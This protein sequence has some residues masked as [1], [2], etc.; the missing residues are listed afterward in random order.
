MWVCVRMVSQKWYDLFIIFLPPPFSDKPMWYFS[1]SLNCPAGESH[2]EGLG[3]CWAESKSLGEIQT[4]RW[5]E[6]W[7][8]SSSSIYPW[9]YTYWVATS[10][11]LHWNLA[12]ENQGQFL[13]QEIH[14]QCLAQD[15]AAADISHSAS[16]WSGA[17][18]WWAFN[19]VSWWFQA[20]LVYLR[21]YMLLWS[22]D[23][24]WPVCLGWV[25]TNQ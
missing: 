13:E 14:P 5:Q 21:P 15:M 22:Y 3:S 1:R 24:K 9:E 8:S 23:A 20:S 4:A 12:M 19:T 16:S 18:Q 10:Y 2:A 25:K 6:T 17:D 7:G 11:L